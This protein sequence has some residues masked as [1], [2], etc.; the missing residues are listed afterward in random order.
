MYIYIY[1]YNRGASD[2]RDDSKCGVASPLG[3]AE[4][5][6]FLEKPTTEIFLKKSSYLRRERNFLRRDLITHH[7]EGNE[8]RDENRDGKYS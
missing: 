1:I 6:S 8:K 5:S 7:R 3:D 4:A 2:T